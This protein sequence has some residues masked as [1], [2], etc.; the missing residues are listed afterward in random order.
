MNSHTTAE[1]AIQLGLRVR[2]AR[3]DAHLSVRE[4]ARRMNLSAS[5]V[6]Q[7]ELGKTSP[8]IGTLFALVSELGMSLD[9]VVKETEAA[10]PHSTAGTYG[11]GQRDSMAN[12]H[13]ADLGGSAIGPDTQRMD[14]PSYASPGILRK[15]DR[16]ELTV[17]GVRWERL[18][19]DNDPAVEFLRVTYKGGTE[20]C[21]SD[22]LLR[23]DG[24]EYFHILSGV[25]K[26]QVGFNSETLETGDSISFDSSNPHRLSNP[27][28][29]T[30]EAIWVVVGR[31]SGE[32]QRG[33]EAAALDAGTLR[34]SPRGDGMREIPKGPASLPMHRSA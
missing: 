22:N 8:S 26:V 19:V 12:R 32:M 13:A 25:L 24:R 1:A 10:L 16:A 17:A 15:A 21:P 6:S 2:E 28:S 5:F 20:S 3:V 7:I 9:S 11:S 33:S 34:V 31:R 18:T 23:H 27:F 14:E 29:E 30:C 4:L